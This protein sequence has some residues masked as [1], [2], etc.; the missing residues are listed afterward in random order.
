MTEYENVKEI[1]DGVYQIGDKF[2][3]VG[4]GA[5]LRTLSGGLISFLGPGGHAVELSQEAVEVIKLD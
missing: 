5:D 3:A 4:Q 2:Y 1:V